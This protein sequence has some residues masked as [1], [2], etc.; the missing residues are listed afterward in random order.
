MAIIYDEI[1][2]KFGLPHEAYDGKLREAFEA[3]GKRGD[4]T[5]VLLAR[6]IALA[7][8]EQIDKEAKAAGATKTTRASSTYAVAAEHADMCT[9]LCS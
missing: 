8:D 2:Q 4:Q 9:M 6:Y 5:S 3:F 1:V 7:L